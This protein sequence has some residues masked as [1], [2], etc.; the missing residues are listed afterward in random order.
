[1]SYSRHINKTVKLV[2]KILY[3]YDYD[4]DIELHRIKIEVNSDYLDETSNLLDNQLK[5]SDNPKQEVYIKS[6]IHNYPHSEYLSM[7][8]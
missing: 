5:Y 6:L 1:M 2:Q 3:G 4:L 8:Y 7:P